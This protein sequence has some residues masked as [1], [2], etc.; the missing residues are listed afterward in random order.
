[1]HAIK[2]L[3]KKLNAD[4]AYRSQ[5]TTAFSVFTLTLLLTWIADHHIRTQIEFDKGNFLSEMAFQLA[6][7]IDQ[8]MAARYGEIQTLAS[9]E[10]VTSNKFSVDSKR[11]VL[12]RLHESFPEF[13]WIGIT[14]T[15]GKVLASAG[16]ILE[17]Q[18][19]STRPWFKQGMLGSYAGD[20]HDAVLLARLL[21]NT[22]SEPM[23]FVD[24]AV[25]LRDSS[26]KIIG[27]LGSHLSWKWAKNLAANLLQ[28]LQDRHGISMSILS[29]NGNALLGKSHDNIAKLYDG[30]I[31]NGYRIESH[32]DG[33]KS[34]V[35]LAVT[36]DSSTTTGY[37][38][39]G[40]T[41]LLDQ[42]TKL[43]FAPADSLGR[44]ILWVGLI[45]ALVVTLLAFQRGMSRIKN[46]KLNEDIA[47]VKQSEEKAQY[48]NE[49]KSNF[50]AVMSHEIRTPM[51]GVL[52]MTDLI[53]Q[54]DLTSDQRKY[55]ELIK[56]SGEGLMTVIND[57]LDFTKIEANK[58][59]LEKI[60]FSF[61]KSVRQALDLM[62]A[63]VQKKGLTLKLNIEDNL[64][65][66]VIGDPTRIRQILA[67]LITNAVK[68]TAQGEILVTLSKD[69]QSQKFLI[70]IKDQGIG[71]APES[72]ARIFQRFE[73]ADS[74]TNRQFGGTGLGLSICKY[75]AEQMG[76]DIG[77][78]SRLGEGSTF[79]FTLQLQ[80]DQSVQAPTV[81][82]NGDAVKQCALHILIGEDNN[83]N[84]MIIKN[85][86]ERL[87]HVVTLATNGVE[88]LKELVP[89]KHFDMV[90]LDCQMPEM[91]GFEATK[92]IRA[93]AQAFRNIPIIARTASAM[94]GE[95][96]KCIQAGMTDYLSKPLNLQTVGAAIERNT[97]ASIAKTSLTS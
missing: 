27:V 28:P 32:A 18:N 24:I 13:A 47:T 60:P 44:K 33:T 52:G 31:K 46:K 77:V 54:T 88:V 86:L 96:E 63:Q 9:L 62:Q 2:N 17:G 82:K 97:A 1:M 55:A 35:G 93:G 74:S 87:G 71:I 37:A 45:L 5:I 10:Q 91:D 20:V 72:Q 68:F 90:F 8:V 14:D 38:G 7:K 11:A 81:L 29:K 48:Q 69:K 85:I 58:L 94:A 53:L 39:L 41:I 73:Q 64:Q 59:V 36:K 50:I 16:K 21:P 26:G 40:W 61:R 49:A 6:D 19:V 25:P 65:D 95:R 70:Q 56:V 30:K 78:V 57:V 83:I 84:Q 79:W 80:I 4:I 89:G 66:A 34:L 67:N 75:L 3:F 42:D 12:D 23:R 51:N 15:D 43:A 22:D 76:G 92:K